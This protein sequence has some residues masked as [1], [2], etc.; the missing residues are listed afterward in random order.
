MNIAAYKLKREQLLLQEPKYRSLCAVCV[1]PD[2]SCYCSY[3]LPFDP[4][5][6]FAVLIHPIEVKRRIATGRM[7]HLCLKDSYLIQGQDYTKNSTVNNLI[8]DTE[9]NSVILYPGPKSKNISTISELE[10]EDLFP[11]N[12]KLRIFVIDGTWA[13]ARKMTRQSENLKTLPR[14]CFSP[15][16]PSNF[17]VRK[18]PKPN[19][20]STIEAIHHTIELIGDSQDFDVRSRV[21]DRLLNVFNFMVERQLHFIKESQINNRASTYRR[22]GQAKINT[23]L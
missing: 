4:K 12:K 22:E 3:V 7:S 11:K 9:Y 16:R 21:H 15:S 17:R 2:F 5:I 8:D 6:N 23:V 20:Y 18:Q 14:I 13:T 10:K 1:Q 19:C